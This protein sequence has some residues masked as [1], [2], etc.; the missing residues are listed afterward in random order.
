MHTTKASDQLNLTPFGHSRGSIVEKN[1]FMNQ[2]SFGAIVGGAERNDQNQAPGSSFYIHDL[3]D[4]LTSYIPVDFVIHS[5]FPHPHDSHTYVAVPKIL[6]KAA[7]VRVASREVSSFTSITGYD[8]YGHAA[9]S[10]SGDCF[11]TAE[12][13]AQG[14]GKVGI[15]NS[16]DGFLQ[17][18]ID[19]PSYGPHDCKLVDQGRTLAIALDGT[20]S[21][22]NMWFKSQNSAIYFISMEDGSVLETSEFESLSTMI[23]H[24][25]ISQTGVV[26]GALAKPFKSDESG[27]LVMGR[28]GEKLN[29]CPSPDEF[30]ERFKT[31]S[32]SLVIDERKQVVVL[33]SPEANLVS[34]WDLRSQSF[35][36]GFDIPHPRGVTL[37]ESHYYVS[38]KNG[39]IHRINSDNLESE[40]VKAGDELPSSHLSF[41][42]ETKFRV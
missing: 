30:Q 6:N 20:I 13:N 8:F 5:L 7:I 25:Q 36:R 10:P 26:V 9:Y 17:R 42:P 24:F 19:L 34:F 22:G 2:K 32:L 18:E 39:K 23:G 16:I 11:Y 31:S 35:I 40:V 15:R 27:V 38:A 29:L 14:K 41:I 28:R 12:R 1:N 21:R 3:R 37:D 33:T 4:N